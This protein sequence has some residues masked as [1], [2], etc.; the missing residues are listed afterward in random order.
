MTEFLATVGS[1][2][3]M[4]SQLSEQV[5]NFLK[6]NDAHLFFH[7]IKKQFFVRVMRNNKPIVNVQ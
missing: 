4:L 6:I 1:R 3:F 2:K 5:A 7:Q